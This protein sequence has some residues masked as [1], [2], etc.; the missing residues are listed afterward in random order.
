MRFRVHRLPRLRE[1]VAWL[2]VAL[3][4]SALPSTSSAE[5]RYKRA[6]ACVSAYTQG[7]QREEAGRLREAQELFSSCSKPTCGPFLHEECVE[8]YKEIDTQIPTLVPIVTDE[9]GEA[10]IDV[11]VRVDGSLLTSKA[12][13]RAVRIDPG[14]HELTFSADGGLLAIRKITIVRGQRDRR[15]CVRVSSGDRAQRD[16]DAAQDC[17]SPAK[18]DAD[19]TP[20]VRPGPRPPPVP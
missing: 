13:G 6:P 4:V 5:R 17:G 16:G 3:I 15:I 10:L 7:Q 9:T 8:R 18:D 20:S 19:V 14:K 11:Q 2:G 1:T 12:D